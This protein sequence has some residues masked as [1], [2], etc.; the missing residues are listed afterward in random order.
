MSDRWRDRSIAE[1]GRVVTGTTPSTTRTDYFGGSIPFATPGDLGK[2]LFLLET[3]RTLTTTGLEQAKAIPQGSILFSCIGVIGKAAIAG[4]TLATNQQI[5]ALVCD[6]KEV[7]NIFVYYVLRYRKP[8][9]ESL[10]GRQVVSIVN[11]STFERFVLRLPPL[12][13][14]RRIGLILRTWERGVEEFNNLRAAVNRQK[15]A[16]LHA[17]LTERHRFPETGNRRW[18]TVFLGDICNPK[19]WR[20]LPA[21]ALS[22]SSEGVP[23]FGATGL[24]GYFT[25]ANHYEDTVIIS[26]RGTC[27]EVMIVPGPSYITGNAM[28]LDELH[29]DVIGKQLLAEIVRFTGTHRIVSGSA[30]PQITR[31]SLMDFKIRIPPKPVQRHLET[32]LSTCDRALSLLTS[33]IRLLEKQQRG[34]MQE[35]LR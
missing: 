1:I 2:S 5:N 9:I 19:Q 15:D 10:A 21:S 11:K 18:K 29:E 23:V 26:C 14:Q 22:G 28:C 7:D 16:L 6:A 3:A 24:I 34:L 20:T 30:Q 8:E 33:K 27:G 17:I 4:R 13:E 12:A 32:L 25:E 31:Q 35:L